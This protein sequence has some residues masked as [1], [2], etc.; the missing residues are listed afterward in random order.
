[1]KKQLY[2]LILILVFVPTLVQLL[3][4]LLHLLGIYTTP[5]ALLGKLSG[6]GWLGNKI[7]AMLT[8][9][10]FPPHAN[11]TAVG[12]FH[13]GG[14]TL[15]LA[16]NA[17]AVALAGRRLLLSPPL[18]GNVPAPTFEKAQT[19]LAWIALGLLVLA[20]LQKTVGL[21]VAP[22]DRVISQITFGKVHGADHLGAI[23]LAFTFWW[24]EIRNLARAV[25][26][27]G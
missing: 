1:M 8:V 23:L 26:Q 14:G 11:G 16:L 7:L 2:G 18:G 6:A 15:V 17:V 20:L 4:Q 21:P 13:G 19:L 10:G 5:G 25:A 24:T 12:P 9:L 3:D 22:L 27:A